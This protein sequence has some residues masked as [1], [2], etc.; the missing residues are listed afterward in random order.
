MSSYSFSADFLDVFS[1]PYP[2]YFFYSALARVA[3][4]F[5]VYI[6]MAYIVFFTSVSSWWN[7][8]RSLAEI[9]DSNSQ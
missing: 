9:N 8:Q 3:V 5:R 4:D 7:K 6:T 1:P 2:L